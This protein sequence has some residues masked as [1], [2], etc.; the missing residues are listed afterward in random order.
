M[1]YKIPAICNKMQNMLYY[2]IRK[3]GFPLEEWV[4]IN[5]AVKILGVNRSTLYRWSKAGKLPIYKVVGKSKI[6]K[7]DIDKLLSD[8][9]MLHQNN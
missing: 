9:K 5:D 4:S 3:E 2:L 8:V 6:K 1:S 7:T